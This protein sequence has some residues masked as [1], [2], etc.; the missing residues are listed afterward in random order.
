MRIA[1]VGGWEFANGFRSAGA[2]AYQV[3]G[4]EAARDT[5]ERI[6]APIILL[7]ESVSAGLEKFIDE[8]AVEKK[9]S[10]VVLRDG[11]TS[12][13]LGAHAV[14]KSIERATGMAEK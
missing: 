10:I 8:K 6:D 13:D 14:R 2:E 12:A 7:A 1:A 9:V 5:I 3:D 11:I 4:P